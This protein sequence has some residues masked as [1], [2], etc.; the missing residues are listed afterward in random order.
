M[1]ANYKLLRAVKC[2]A[3]VAVMLTIVSAVVMQ[4]WNALLP[5]LFGWHVI[6]F[7]Q[8]L[9]L[10][11]LSRLLFG[12]MRGPGRWGPPWMH[13]MRQRW[14]KDDAGR[15]REI[16]RDVTKAVA[17]FSVAVAVQSQCKR[18]TDSGRSTIRTCSLSRRG[19]S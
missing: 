12:G 8:A 3:L 11:I 7:G 18:K 15:T 14:G 10:L 5:N 6:G 4:L 9:G 17:D 19:D 13:H 16:S 1:R 2:I